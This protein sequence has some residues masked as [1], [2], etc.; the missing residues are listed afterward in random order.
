[1]L[2]VTNFQ[3][4]IPNFQFP[5][6]NSQLPIPNYQLETYLRWFRNG[7]LSSTGKCF[8]IGNTVR[9]AL[10]KFEDI[11]KPF[12]GSTDAHTAGSI[13]RLAPVPLF[14]AKNSLEVLGKSAESSR[15]T[16]GAATCVDA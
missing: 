13:M 6:T 11:R 9:Q 7:H 12:C 3:F 14:Y 5:I 10:G 16:H 8:D 1:M 15:T 2:F 4:P